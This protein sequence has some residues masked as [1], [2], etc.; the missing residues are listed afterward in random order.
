MGSPG[1]IAAAPLLRGGHPSL[2]Q[3]DMGGNDAKEEAVE[4][5]LREIIDI[6]T[7]FDSAL[8]I[9]ELGGN[10]IGE[11][12]ELAL[13]DLKAVHPELDVARDKPKGNDSHHA[14]QEV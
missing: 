10:E 12:V 7:S 8:R 2:V 3:L 5:L 4:N 14:W 1:I 9:I 11:S 13:K 6:N